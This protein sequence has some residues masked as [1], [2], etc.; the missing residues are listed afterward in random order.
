MGASWKCGPLGP[1]LDL[2]TQNLCFDVHS[3]IWEA[4]EKRPPQS[5]PTPSHWLKWLANACGSHHKQ[6]AAYDLN[7]L[8]TTW[9]FKM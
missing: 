1:S 4:L 8:M 5:Q 2:L 6:I 3:N 7:D 9:Y